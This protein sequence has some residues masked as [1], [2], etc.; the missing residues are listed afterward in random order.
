MKPAMAP[1]TLVTP[2]P[3]PATGYRPKWDAPKRTFDPKFGCLR[4]PYG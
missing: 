4:R 3:E 1:E 2:L